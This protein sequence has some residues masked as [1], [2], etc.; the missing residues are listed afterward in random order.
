M[1][2]PETVRMRRGEGQGKKGEKGKVGESGEELKRKYLLLKEK[3]LQI[4]KQ[5][6]NSRPT[7]QSHT[8]AS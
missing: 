7:P 2:V 4:Q 5:S 6:T 3:L 8:H 1:G